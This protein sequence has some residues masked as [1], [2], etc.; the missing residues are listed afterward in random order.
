MVKSAAHRG[1]T[2]NDARDSCRADEGD[3]L[4]VGNKLEMDFINEISARFV[5]HRQHLW[6]GL[7]DLNEEN[8][9]VWSD[10]TPFNPSVYN[11]WGPGE[12]NNFLG[13]HCVELFNKV[14]N[15]NICTKEFGYI[16]EK[17]RGKKFIKCMPDFLSCT[18]YRIAE[19]L[20]LV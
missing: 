14:W 17:P 6:I 5:Y 16:C 8:K 1:Q 11:N 13:E 10:G 3:L 19:R 18:R 9:F 4:S 7:N 20:G 15:D 12:P 2:W